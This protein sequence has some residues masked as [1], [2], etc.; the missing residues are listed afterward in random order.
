MGLTLPI[1]SSSQSPPPFQW[2]EWYAGIGG[3]SIHI[4]EVQEYIHKIFDEQYP[5]CVGTVSDTVYH[6]HS[7]EEAA[8]SLKEK[9]LSAGADLVG[10]CEIEPSDIY[11]GKSVHEKYAIAIGQKMRWAAFQ[12]VP[13]DESAIECLR[14][15]HSLGEIVIALADYIRSLGWHCTVEHPIGDTDVLHIPIALKAGFGELGRHGSVINPKIGPLFRMGCIL[16]SM[17]L[18]TDKP[19]DAGIARFCDNCRA[20]RIYCPA[21]AIP[22]E[23]NALAGKDH[24]GND[25][26]TVDTG[27][28]F[29]YFGK[30]KYCSACLPVCAYNHKEWAF[31]PDI[32]TDLFPSVLFSETPTPYDGVSSEK[33]HNYP[34]FR[35]NEPSP[36][37]SKRKTK[38]L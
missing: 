23:R 37:E 9:V 32:K 5:R 26:Y 16:T 22:E 12:T 2:D 7:P 30:E 1:L 31:E 28:C 36:W 15:Y 38:H 6:F 27:K 18:A 14:I 3:R 25:R 20:C 35:R 17:P 11:K 29:P 34:H 24:L 8:L 13:S 19:I 21:D 33:R 4:P 10:I